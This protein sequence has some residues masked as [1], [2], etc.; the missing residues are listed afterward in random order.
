MQDQT[1]YTAL[2]KFHTIIGTIDKAS[3]NPFFRSIYGS[4]PDIQKAISEP[5]LE[6]G[7]IIVHQ[8]GE[9]DTMQTSIVHCK[10]GTSITSTFKLHIKGD[11]SQ[12]WG[13]AI[14][15]A[16]RYAIGALLN[17]CIDVDD[18]GNASSKRTQKRIYTGTELFDKAV[19]FLQDG[20]SI[21]AIQRKYRISDTTKNELMQAV[22]LANEI[23][24]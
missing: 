13:A 4:L 24:K 8:L 6:C 19:A 5:L 7:L 20:G 15:Y 1:I 11:D 12:A 23:K 3:T 2:F 18:D 9:D 21:E 16:K 10:T 14:T 17:L 22:T